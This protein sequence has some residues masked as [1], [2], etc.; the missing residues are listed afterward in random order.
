MK[1]YDIFRP[2]DGGWCLWD[3][4]QAE[5]RRAAVRKVPSIMG[6]FKVSLSA[7]Q[8]SIKREG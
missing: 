6:R 7:Q 3:R 5:S 8:A 1:F 4:V 2:T